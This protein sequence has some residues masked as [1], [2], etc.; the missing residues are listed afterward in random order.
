[1]AL[2]LMVILGA[3]SWPALDRPMATQ[4][5]RSGADDVRTAWVRARVAAMNS[6]A[7][8]RFRYVPG[9]DHYTV[10]CQPTPEFYSDTDSSAFGTSGGMEPDPTAEFKLNRCL[11]DNVRFSVS[12]GPTAIDSRAEEAA[13][14]ATSTSDDPQLALAEPILFYPDGT[15]S[16][17][18]LSVQNQYGR[19]I[20]LS[21]RGLTGVTTVSP[22]QD[23]PPDAVGGK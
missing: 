16:T 7:T 17:A 1:L 8:Y 19:M 4:S 2:A 23:A 5:L 15:T 13:S 9:G 20:E 22:L 3:L 14:S 10:D 21:L 6:G 11:P 18:V 12:G